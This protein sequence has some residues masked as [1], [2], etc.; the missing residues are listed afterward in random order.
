MTFYNWENSNI[1]IKKQINKFID[2][3]TEQL[4]SNFIGIYLYGS[5]AMNCFNPKNSDIDIIVVT[6]KQID[7]FS[8]KKIIEELLVLSNNPYP[9]EVSFII[10]DD[11]KEWKYPTPFD[12]H[13]S[14]DWRYRFESRY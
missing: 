4:G 13:Y 3:I 1:T 9:I 11:L 8:K 5:L 10:F 14:E 2:I 6:S 12:L 7:L